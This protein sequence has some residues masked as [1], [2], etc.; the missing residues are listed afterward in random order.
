MGESTGT[1]VASPEESRR[2]HIR[3]L[4]GQIK[5]VKREIAAFESLFAAYTEEGDK[6]QIALQ[7]NGLKTQRQ[8][9]PDWNR[10]CLMFPDSRPRHREVGPTGTYEA[11]PALA[12]PGQQIVA[13]GTTSR[14]SRRLKRVLGEN[15]AKL[16]GKMK[17][18]LWRAA[19]SDA[20]FCGCRRGRSRGK[21]NQRGAVRKVRPQNVDP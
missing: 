10:S 17:G 1:P 4:G 18:D 11:K 9:C 15:Y 12:G 8:G 7:A 20:G 2:I 3:V 16:K 5:S 14:R 19:K 6:E 13:D 21:D